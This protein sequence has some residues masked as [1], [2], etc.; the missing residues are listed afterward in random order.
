MMAA[1]ISPPRSSSV[2]PIEME[3]AGR[4]RAAQRREPGEAVEDRR[5]HRHERE[6][7]ERADGRGQRLPP[8]AFGEQERGHG[9]AG[10]RDDRDPRRLPAGQDQR[11]DELDDDGER[12]RQRDQRADAAPAADQDHGRREQ[13]E[14]Q[15][16]RRD[17]V[18]VVDRDEARLRV[19][20]DVDD[21]LVADDEL[22]PRF[23]PGRPLDEALDESPVFGPPGIP[24]RTSIRTSGVP[25]SA[26][27]MS[28]TIRPWTS[29]TGGGP[30]AGG[31][32]SGTKTKIARTI[33]N[34]PPS[35]RA[36][37][38]RP[39][40]GTC[41]S[42]V[43]LTS[44]RQAAGGRV[45]GAFGA[46]L[47]RAQVRLDA[48]LQRRRP[49]RTRMSV[50]R[51]IGSNVAAWTTRVPPASGSSRHD[52]SLSKPEPVTRSRKSDSGRASRLST[53]ARSAQQAEPCCARPRRRRGR[54]GRLGR[55][56]PQLGEERAT[57][58]RDRGARP[59]RCAAAPGR[60]RGARR[61]RSPAGGRRARR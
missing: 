31:A 48:G 18:A 21:D 52:H 56:E 15:R 39:A 8:R 25:G 41:V 40:N 54:P 13:P 11:H 7:H 55:P 28:S 45:L 49:R 36:L 17:A 35:A 12:E 19:G 2:P 29:S 53:R 51:S 3:E 14:Q 16:E 33:S 59:D 44:R 6:R 32:M 10:R 61:R 37:R 42:G 9:H 4:L 20:R 46:L 57:C 23:Q 43:A 26:V 60:R 24:W 5:E 27:G 30:S 22:G 1:R 38:R 34:P 58:C 50:Q 47:E